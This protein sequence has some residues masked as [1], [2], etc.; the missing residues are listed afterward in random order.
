MFVKHGTGPLTASD[1]SVLSFYFVLEERGAKPEVAVKTAF[2]T[3]DTRHFA[4]PFAMGAVWTIGPPTPFIEW[5]VQTRLTEDFGA[6]DDLA[7]G[8]KALEQ[9]IIDFAQKLGLQLP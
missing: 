6:P 2:L 8:D 1:I 5:G 7:G 9:Q 4:R 3:T